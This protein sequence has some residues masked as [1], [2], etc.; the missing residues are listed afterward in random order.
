[1]PANPTRKSNRC[2]LAAPPMSA[3]GKNALWRHASRVCFRV[4]RVERSRSEL[5]NWKLAF[6]AWTRRQPPDG[7]TH[8]SVRKLA[9]HLGVPLMTVARD[10]QRAGLRRHRLER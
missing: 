9:T 4:T 5:L 6:L 2:F 1:M 3:V 7:S 10:W 8:W